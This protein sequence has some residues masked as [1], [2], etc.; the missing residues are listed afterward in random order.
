MA[1]PDLPGPDSDVGVR[2]ARDADERRRARA[3]VDA[4][5]LSPPPDPDE[6]LVAPDPGSDRLAGALALA[7]SRVAAVAVRRGRRG[8]EV[9]TALVAAAARRRPDGRLVACFRPSVAPFYEALGFGIEADAGPEG[10]HRGV[11]EVDSRD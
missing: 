6:W 4:A 8:R 10:R 7:G 11:L 9:G 2:P 3:I 5:M 1:A